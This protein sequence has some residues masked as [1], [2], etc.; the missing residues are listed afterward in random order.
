M[1]GR[2]VRY[3]GP[4]YKIRLQNRFVFLPS[5]KLDAREIKY[6]HLEI[7]F[8]LPGSFFASQNIGEGKTEFIFECLLFS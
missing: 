7:F 6:Q 1:H 3:G 5:C 8:V 2:H 4:H